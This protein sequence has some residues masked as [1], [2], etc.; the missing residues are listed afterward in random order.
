[1][2]DKSRSLVGVKERVETEALHLQSVELNL[3]AGWVKGWGPPA[4]SQN[5]CVAHL[6]RSLLHACWAAVPPGC[7]SYL[8]QIVSESHW[9][10]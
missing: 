10:L 2:L 5:P 4:A 9:G 8:T 1:M 7:L 3:G 6:A